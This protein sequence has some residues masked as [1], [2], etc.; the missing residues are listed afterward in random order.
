MKRISII[1]KMIQVDYALTSLPSLTEY[2][3]P[4]S[5]TSFPMKMYC[6]RGSKKK[7]NCE[8]NCILQS[9]KN[10]YCSTKNIAEVTIIGD[11]IE[12]IWLNK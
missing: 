11:N 2:I 9:Y 10:I 3:F 4:V 8:K 5:S 6:E 12:Q 7:Q 1:L